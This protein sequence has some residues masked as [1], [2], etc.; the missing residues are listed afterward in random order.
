MPCYDGSIHEDMHALKLR[1]DEV[2]AL[3]CELCKLTDNRNQVMPPN[4]KKWWDAH[5]IEDAKRNS[6]L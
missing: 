2:T 4:V 1:L 3:L 6:R 5:K